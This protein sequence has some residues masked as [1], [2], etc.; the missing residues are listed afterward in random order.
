MPAQVNLSKIYRTGDGVAED[1]V[2]AYAWCVRA[3]ETGHAG[4]QF[5]L[6]GNHF[7]RGYGVALDLAQAAIWFRKAAEAGD[8]E[9]QFNL[10][11]LCALGG[12]VPMDRGHAMAW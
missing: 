3:A 9:S 10:G 11:R 6:G 2:E 1:P 12:G 5:N 8:V 4:A 7:M